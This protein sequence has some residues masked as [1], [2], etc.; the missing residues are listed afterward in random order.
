MILK[1]P[2]TLAIAATLSIL[3]ASLRAQAATPNAAPS[4]QDASPS[5]AASQT[6][7]L[8]MVPATAMLLDTIDA[9]KMQPGADVKVQLSGKVHLANGPELPTGTVLVGTVVND[10]MNIQGNVK[11]GLC[12]TQAQLKDGKTI[13]IKATIVGAYTD[14]QDAASAYNGYTSQQPNSWTNGTLAIDQIGVASG[15]ELHSRITS[16]ISGVFVATNRDDIRLRKGS[17]INLAI[18]AAPGARQSATTGA[19]S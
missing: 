3:P 15:V 6:E 12:F 9:R 7:A 2:L 5:S 17:D 19:G 16:N 11:L 4:S 8:H 18:A 14:P 13:P 10:D 1:L